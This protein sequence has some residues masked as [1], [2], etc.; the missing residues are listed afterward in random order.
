MHN[1]FKNSPCLR[2]PIGLSQYLAIYGIASFVCCNG[3]YIDTY[4]YITDGAKQLHAFAL[5]LE[6]SS[7]YA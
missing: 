2:A 1:T 4:L 3:E 7:V 6:P 5:R